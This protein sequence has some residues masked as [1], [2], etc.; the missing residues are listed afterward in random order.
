MRIEVPD[1]ND[2][3]LHLLIAPLIAKVDVF[4]RAAPEILPLKEAGQGAIIHQRLHRNDDSP[5]E[6]EVD[7]V[8][9]RRSSKILGADV[10]QQDLVDGPQGEGIEP[11]V[12]EPVHV[13]DV[14][15]EVD[16]LESDGNLQLVCYRVV[17]VLDALAVTQLTQGDLAKLVEAITADLHCPVELAVGYG[18]AGL[19]GVVRV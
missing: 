16:L 17:E 6:L 11:S 3:P 18:P 14:L 10:L 9:S 8:P 19:E 15:V 13:V 12:P 5:V 1:G 4:D 7:H 2:L